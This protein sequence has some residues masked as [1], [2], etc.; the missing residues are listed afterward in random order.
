MLVALADWVQPTADYM[1]HEG[2]PGTLR[3]AVFALLASAVVGILLGTLLTIDFL[4]LRA[5]SSA[6]G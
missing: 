2:L 1:L 4:P 5:L 3:I 6:G